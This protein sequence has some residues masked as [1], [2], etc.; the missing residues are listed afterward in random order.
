MA[1]EESDPAMTSFVHNLNKQ[2]MRPLNKGK[3]LEDDTS[4]LNRRA[5]GKL[6]F[7]VNTF[8]KA[9]EPHFEVVNDGYLRKEIKVVD[10]HGLDKLTMYYTLQNRLLARTYDLMFHFTVPDD[11]REDY[12]ELELEYGGKFSIE[13]AKFVKV[14]GTKSKAILENLNNRLLTDRLKTLD[15]LEFRIRYKPKKKEWDILVT[16]LIGSA[17]WNMIPPAFQVIKPKDVECIRMME[18]FELTAHGITQ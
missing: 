15:F 17:V 3:N 4:S 18:V 6:E 9:L 10:L 16:S 11:S 14:S 13:S 5:N 1:G 2:V 7:V 8:K 12:L